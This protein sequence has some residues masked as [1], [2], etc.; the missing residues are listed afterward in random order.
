LTAGISAE[1]ERERERERARE[2]KSWDL[3]VVRE[4]EYWLSPIAELD[5]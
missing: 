2:R 5:G 3:K 4:K 1:R